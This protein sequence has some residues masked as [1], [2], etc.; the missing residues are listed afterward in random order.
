MSK[1]VAG[2]GYNNRKYPVRVNSKDTDEYVAWHNMLHRCTKHNWE[3]NSSYIDC[4]VSENF[5]SYTFFYEWCQTQV[6]FRNKDENGKFWNLDKDLLIKGNKLYSEDTC[7]FVPHKV[8]TLLTKRYSKRGEFPIGVCWHKATSRYTAQCGEGIGCKPSY[9]GLFD[10]PTEAFQAYKTCKEFRVKEV[11][12]RYKQ[13]LDTR[14]YQ[15]LMKYEVN[16]ND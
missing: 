5:K 6:G 1:L 13:Q 4:G 9:L 2:L 15:A 7:V 14:A 10:T 16:I 11:A 12:E 8:N 3:V